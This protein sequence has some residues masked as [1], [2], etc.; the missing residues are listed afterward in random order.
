MNNPNDPAESKGCTAN[1]VLIKDSTIFVANAG[2]SRSVMAIGG[3]AF[4]L[5]V[6]H[7][8]NLL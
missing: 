7:K 8:P 4:P 2:D 1:V 5:S 3:K 6:D